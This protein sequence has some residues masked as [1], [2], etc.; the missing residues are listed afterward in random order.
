M[1]MAKL[2]LEPE[3]AFEVM[4]RRARAARRPV[5]EIAADVI[6]G[7]VPGPGAEAG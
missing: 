3:E 1:L 7:W 6:A 2:S 5:A 4:R